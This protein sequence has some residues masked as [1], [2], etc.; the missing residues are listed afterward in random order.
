MQ[1]WVGGV[2][3]GRGGPLPPRRRPF[4]FP[5]EVGGGADLFGAGEPFAIPWGG[6]GARLLVGPAL[7][8]WEGEVRTEP[9]NAV[10]VVSF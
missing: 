5:W 4:P 7:P 8:G 1:S 3:Q 2:G 9:S 6:K 10:T